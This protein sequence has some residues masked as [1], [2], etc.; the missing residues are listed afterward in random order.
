MIIGNQ[1]VD[2]LLRLTIQ[3]GATIPI[4][5]GSKINHKIKEEP[6]IKL[7]INILQDSFHRLRI[8]SGHLTKPKPPAFQS[9]TQVPQPEPQSSFEDTVKAFIQASSQNI[10]KLKSA[11]MNNNQTIQGLN[12]NIQELMNVNMS[13]MQELKNATTWLWAIARIYKSLSSSHIKLLLRWKGK[14]AN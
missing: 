13:N 8:S 3:D 5:L 7:I 9:T 4:S 11:T 12:Q 10:Q 6:R 2:L 1:Q 14:L